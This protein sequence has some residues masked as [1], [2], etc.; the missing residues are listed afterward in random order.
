[1]TSVAT[2]V[3]V[4]SLVTSPALA[5]PQMLKAMAHAAAVSGLCQGGQPRSTSTQHKP[6]EGPEILSFNLNWALLLGRG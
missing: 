5:K 6:T 1:M 4:V 3:R 2:S